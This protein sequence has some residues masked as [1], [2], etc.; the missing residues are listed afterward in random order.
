MKNF[1][2]PWGKEEPKKDE[3]KKDEKPKGPLM[4]AVSLAELER[5]GKA[6]SQIKKGTDVPDDPTLIFSDEFTSI[7]IDPN[8]KKFKTEQ[9]DDKFEKKDGKKASYVSKTTFPVKPIIVDKKLTIILIEDTAE[10]AK[11]REIAFK[12]L[13]NHLNPDIVRIIY[14]GE[15][16]NETLISK[17]FDFKD[18]EF[19]CTE[20]SGN[21]ICLYDTLEYVGKMIL[22]TYMKENGTEYRKERISQITIM[23]I[24]TCRDTCSETSK[25]EA[26]ESFCNAIKKSGA[27]TKYFCL[28]ENSFLDAAEIGFRSI[29]SISRN[30]Q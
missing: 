2:K 29:G 24:G 12:L 4:E 13:Q 22:D 25:E 6:P 7:P 16:I 3:S 19:E 23:G 11:E 21:E 15:G 27:L 26:I 30:Y 20:E 18:V 14:Y 5:M 1:F 10:V 28:T 8:A 9:K 17:K